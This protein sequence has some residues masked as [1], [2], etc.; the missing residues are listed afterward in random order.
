[1]KAIRKNLEGGVWSGSFAAGACAALLL[2][3]GC[4]GLTEAQRAWQ[5][6][7]LY[8]EGTQSLEA[9]DAAG[10]VDSLS[11][12]AALVP[13][14]SEIQNH[15]GLAYWAL[16]ERAE[17]ESAFDQALELDC[18]NEAARQNRSGLLAERSEGRSESDF[19]A[20]ARGGAIRGASASA[21]GGALQDGR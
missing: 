2:M 14:A 1:M 15:L 17:A 8:S 3:S 21:P 6:S 13:H 11:R 20:V 5:G 18:E 4:A 12:A 9:G 10:A 16:G 7:R 19:D